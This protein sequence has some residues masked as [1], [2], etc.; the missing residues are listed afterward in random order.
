MQNCEKLVYVQT[1]KV[2]DIMVTTWGSFSICSCVGC[3][4]D[5][6]LFLNH[7]MLLFILSAASV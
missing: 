6:H 3:F 7:F 1:H 5:C 2:A 4:T